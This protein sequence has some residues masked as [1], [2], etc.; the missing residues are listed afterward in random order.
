MER[1]LNICLIN[2]YDI[3]GGAARA[4][5]RL[6]K[7]LTLQNH[8]S[9]MLVRKK[10][11][12]DMSVLALDTISDEDKAE[13]E[14][15]SVIQKQLINQNRTDI[16]DTLFSLPYPGYDLSDTNLIRSADVINLHWVSYFQSVESI[17]SLLSLHKPVVWT[18]H[19]QWAF[20]GGCHYS[21]GCEKYTQQCERCPQ[22]LDDS[23]RLPEMILK[24]K[25]NYFDRSLVIVSPSNW[26]AQCTRKSTVFKNCRIEVIPNGLDIDTFRPTNKVQAKKDLSI[27]PET[28]TILFGAISHTKKRKGFQQLCKAFDY[29]HKSEK[30]A[31][32]IRTGKVRI[33]T[34]GTADSLMKEVGIPAVSFGH[35][36]SDERLAVIYSAADFMVLPSLEDNLPNIMVECLSCGTPVIAFETGGVPDAVK[37]N[38]T[39]YLA[40]TFDT[41]EMGSYILDM[42]FR[43]EI[44]KR[45]SSNA[46]ELAENHFSMQMQTNGYLKLFND[47][48]RDRAG[49][50]SDS[51]LA[52]NKECSPSLSSVDPAF[53]SLYR[54]FTREVLNRNNRASDSVYK[55]SF[56]RIAS[57]GGKVVKRVGRPVK[58][59]IKYIL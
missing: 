21:A 50:G 49:I 23:D 13:E 28:T 35:T 16:S 33:M 1:P 9:I 42:L 39:G 48:I 30:F 37:H 47:L 14:I 3:V 58:R 5:Y 18:L 41:D 36:N 8:N 40:A 32:L 15:F 34:F 29:C 46:R 31:E 7:G 12:Q 6:H 52:E 26:L 44:R 59:W 22:L 38:Q 17:A 54:R 43:P 55:G 57:I 51:L 4:A 56:L 53:F 10:K 11:S 2:T 24:N 45:M 25:L 20:T 27:N 19:D